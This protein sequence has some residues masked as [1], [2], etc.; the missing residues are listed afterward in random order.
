MHR[1][2]ASVH[3]HT[4]DRSSDNDANTNRL[5]DTSTDRLAAVSPDA[6]QSDTD[7][8]NR[9]FVPGNR[10]MV[11]GPHLPQS[12][13][14]RLDDDRRSVVDIHRAETDAT[15]SDHG[16]DKRVTYIKY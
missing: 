11:T 14:H 15:E 9:H 13:E 10:L 7:S 6:L 4:D 16:A 5:F 12:L 3:R 2:S 1:R 8:N